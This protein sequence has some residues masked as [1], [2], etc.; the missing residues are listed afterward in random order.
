[1]LLGLRVAV[2]SAVDELVDDVVKPQQVGERFVALE[3]VPKRME[4]F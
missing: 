1:M 4:K 3:V 2:A